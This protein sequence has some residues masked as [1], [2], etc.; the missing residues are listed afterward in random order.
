MIL[1]A[2]Y[3]LI[4]LYCILITDMQTQILNEINNYIIITIH[5]EHLIFY[6]VIWKALKAMEF[7]QGK[8]QQ[9]HF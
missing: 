5:Q 2:E 9:L 8:R 3:T 7:L 4:A 1:P 6:F